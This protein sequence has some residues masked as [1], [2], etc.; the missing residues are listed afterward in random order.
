MNE[1]KLLKNL[2]MLKSFD[3]SEHTM[4]SIKRNLV[5]PIVASEINTHKY[6]IATFMLFIALLTGVIQYNQNP[7]DRA[8]RVI[9]KV[10]STYTEK[11]LDKS[12]KA[13]ASLNLNGEPGK[14]TKEECEKIY[15]DF[16]KYIE[17]YKLGIVNST[18][19]DDIRIHQKIVKIEEEMAAKWPKFQ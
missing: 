3:P 12:V 7:M 17:D 15:N 9:A 11:N 6:K 18:N 19:Q 14:Y 2:E 8:T 4:N 10:D 13:L 1:S 5:V 16:Y